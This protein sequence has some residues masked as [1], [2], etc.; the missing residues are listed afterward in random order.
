MND[1]FE[2]NREAAIAKLSTSVDL[3]EDDRLPLATFNLCHSCYFPF[4]NEDLRQTNDYK[5][6]CIKTEMN[7]DP[8]WTDP[9]TNEITEIIN[10][11]QEVCEVDFGKEILRPEP[12]L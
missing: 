1:S 6:L 9:I 4:S 3:T 11:A 7:P 2:R 10:E 5:F 8:C 12:T